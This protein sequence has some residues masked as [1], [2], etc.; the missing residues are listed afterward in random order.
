MEGQATGSCS[1]AW[2][3]PN[4]SKE[5]VGGGPGVVARLHQD[6]RGMLLEFDAVDLT[7][8]E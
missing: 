4:R 7:Y 3:E 2:D 8:L 1:S 6:A 5:W